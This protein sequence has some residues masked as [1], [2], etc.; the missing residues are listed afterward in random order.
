M[1]GITALMKVMRELTSS[2]CS[3]PLE[4][5]VRRRPST[6]QEA[7]LTRH[8]ICRLLLRQPHGRWSGMDQPGSAV[9]AGQHQGWSLFPAAPCMLTESHQH[10]LWAI[11]RARRICS[12]GPH[13]IGRE[14]ADTWLG[15]SCPRPRPGLRGLTC[16]GTPIS[17]CLGLF[18]LL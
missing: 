4:D 10:G 7:A 9:G 6:C 11:H 8:R 1:S 18:R 3:L 5:T 2:P 14:A 16:Q 13:P 12:L 15:S 17:R